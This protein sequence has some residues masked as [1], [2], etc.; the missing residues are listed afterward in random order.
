MK[1]KE[2]KQHICLSNGDYFGFH[3]KRIKIQEID[4]T[5]THYNNHYSLPEHE[6]EMLNII[7]VTGG[8]FKE[9]YLNK[10]YYYE[11]GDLVV[12]PKN[13]IH[14]NN[15]LTRRTSVLNIEINPRWLEG[16]NYNKPIFKSYFR[17]NQGFI[18]KPIFKLYDLFKSCDLIDQ[19]LIESLI[20]ELVTDLNQQSDGLK[21]SHDIPQWVDKIE[22]VFQADYSNRYSLKTLAQI[23]NLHPIYLCRAFKQFTGLN[24]GEFSQRIK[25][26]RA[27]QKLAFTDLS[28]TEIALDCG[29]YDQ[30][31]FIKVFKKQMKLTPSKFR[32]YSRNK[33]FI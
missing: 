31:H 23:I 29:F 25:I 27:C 11:I 16:L 21:K 9:K 15:F 24:I 2:E 32:K 20:M 26:D 19:L 14:S 13:Q 18:T 30:S 10:N 1:K 7:L 28:L 17:A 4:M 33:F 22:E 5:Q 12:H 3:G 8:C 6:H